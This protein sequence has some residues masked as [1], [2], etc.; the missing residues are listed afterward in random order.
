[1]S[2]DEE[3]LGTVRY[4]HMESSQPVGGKEVSVTGCTCFVDTLALLFAADLAPDDICS[5]IFS[6]CYDVMILCYWILIVTL[7][8]FQGTYLFITF[9]SS[10]ALCLVP[11]CG[12]FCQQAAYVLGILHE[13]SH[14]KIIL[15]GY[16]Q[17]R[18]RRTD[19]CG[20]SEFRSRYLLTLDLRYIS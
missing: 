19:D 1:M 18:H 5:Y 4:A 20:F 14:I 3:G 16:K 13:K 10:C 11:L 7:N 12:S 15:S 17:K 2:D 9:A 6:L 8:Y